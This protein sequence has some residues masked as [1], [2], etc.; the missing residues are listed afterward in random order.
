M[1]VAGYYVLLQTH[2]LLS[3]ATAELLVFVCLHLQLLGCRGALAERD[4]AQIFATPA[5]ICQVPNHPDE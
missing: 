4:P 2:T 5:R 1:L 3:I